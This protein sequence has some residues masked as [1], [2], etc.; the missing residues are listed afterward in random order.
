[1]RGKFRTGEANCLNKESETQLKEIISV[2][3][4]GS[5]SLDEVVAN[6]NAELATEVGKRE[7]LESDVEKMESDV[8]ALKTELAAKD[9]DALAINFL[10]DVMHY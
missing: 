3:I 4:A 7:K 6:L 10:M 9:A 1:L 5:P 8:V 2:I